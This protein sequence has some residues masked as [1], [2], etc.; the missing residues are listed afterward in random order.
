LKRF[1]VHRLKIDKSFV[2]DL[3][4]D[5]NDRAIVATIIS[6][7]KHM[8]LEILAEGVETQEQL[9]YLAAHGCELAQG[10]LLSMPLP[11][12]EFVT[13]WKAWK[14]RQQSTT[15]VNEL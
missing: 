6:M 15:R 10:Y 14:N 1:K 8:G 3:V 9:E 13:F 7:A 4:T 12:A 5:E 11:A 2:R